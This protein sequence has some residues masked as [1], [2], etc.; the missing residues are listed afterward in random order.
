MI[1]VFLGILICLE[2]NA[3]ALAT[4][5]S[6]TVVIMAGSE[7]PPPK[8]LKWVCTTLFISHY[9]NG[10]HYITIRNNDMTIVYVCNITTIVSVAYIGTTSISKLCYWYSSLFA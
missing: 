4:V 10:E 9:N 7:Y 5:I 1:L 3:V 6:V 2:L 8:C